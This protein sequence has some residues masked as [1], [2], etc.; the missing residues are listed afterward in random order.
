MDFISRP[1]KCFTACCASVRILATSAAVF[2]YFGKQYLKW[3]I[4]SLF[5]A[6]FVH[7]LRLVQECRA[8]SAVTSAP[9]RAV[10]LSTVAL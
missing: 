1:Q 10:Q 4:I 9:C 3:D 6:S 2:V 8:P 5:C 7:I